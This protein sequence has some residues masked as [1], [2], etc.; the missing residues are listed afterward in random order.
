MFA[1][2]LLVFRECG[3]VE[4]CVEGSGYMLRFIWKV[5]RESMVWIASKR[6]HDSHISNNLP[7]VKK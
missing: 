7:F 3:G 4:M 6:L 1:C 5:L 2:G